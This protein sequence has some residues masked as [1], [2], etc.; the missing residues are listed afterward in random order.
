MH[1]DK[2]NKCLN[3]D[4][5]CDSSLA[6]EKADVLAY[7]NWLAGPAMLAPFATFVILHN[8]VTE[9]MNRKFFSEGRGKLHCVVDVAKRLKP[10]LG[11]SFEPRV[12]APGYGTQQ[13]PG[14]G[15]HRLI[16]CSDTTTTS[17]LF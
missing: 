11:F 5:E 8:L 16:N 10:F 2:L 9:S 7:H 17:F 4:A 6:L 3:D 14:I 15:K 1:M 12:I 13:L